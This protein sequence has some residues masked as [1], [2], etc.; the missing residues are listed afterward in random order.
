M[1]RATEK[2]VVQ[3]FIVLG[4][5]TR[6]GVMV[7]MNDEGNGSNFDTENFHPCFTAAIQAASRWSSLNLISPPSLGEYKDL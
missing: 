4:R 2:D 7:D 3:L 6:L 1:R 5:G